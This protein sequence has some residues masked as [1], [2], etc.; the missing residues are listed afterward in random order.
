MLKGNDFNRSN[1]ILLNAVRQS[2]RHNKKIRKS[3]ENSFYYCELAGFRSTWQRRRVDSKVKEG[4]NGVSTKLPPKK[5]RAKLQFFNNIVVSLL[6]FSNL[7][8]YT[9]F[10]IEIK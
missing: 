10:C 8:P 9:V 5:A 6:V 4:Q 3:T 2:D 1:Y 7:K